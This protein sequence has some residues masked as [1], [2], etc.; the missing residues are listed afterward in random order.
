MCKRKYLQVYFE[1]NQAK[2][3]QI[4]IYEVKKLNSSKQ[5]NIDAILLYISI[6]DNNIMDLF[7]T[8]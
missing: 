4:K 1:K 3:W 2:S 5:I 8:P 6:G 7:Y